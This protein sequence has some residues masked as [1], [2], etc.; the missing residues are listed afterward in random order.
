[1]ANGGT[2]IGIKA[3]DGVVLAGEKR[4][5]YN[6][7]ILS[8]A[9]RKV[10]PITDHVGVAF[11]GLYGD[12]QMLVRMLKTEA[13]Y[14]HLEIGKEISVRA[15]AK[16][17]S[18]ILYSYKLFPFYAESIVGGVD[19]KGPQ[20][21]VLDPVGSLIEDDYTATGTGA[22]LAMGVIETNYRKDIKVEEAVELAKKA[23]EEAIRRDAISGDGIDLLVITREGYKLEEILFKR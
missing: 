14:Y 17:L 20:V 21:Y 5:S 11:A 13:Q 18:N 19:E 4:I 1:M 3:V 12:T 9:A 16:V 7:F 22:P 23:I 2:T 6:G 15:L 10:H 8:K